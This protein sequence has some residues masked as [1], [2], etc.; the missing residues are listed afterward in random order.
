KVIPLADARMD[1]VQITKDGN[2]AVGQDDKEYVDDWKPQ[3]T[4]IYR[5]NANTGERTAILKANE[6]SLGLSADGKYF[7][8]WKGGHVWSYNI[9]NNTHAN[10]TKSA[11]VSFVNIEED[12]V[13]EKPVYGITGFSKDGKSIILE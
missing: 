2:W 3:L 10:I 12:H 5:V 6:R 1:R 11:P 13:G 8:Y 7:L 4:D 9:A